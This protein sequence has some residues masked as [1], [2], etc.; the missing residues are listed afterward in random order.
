[1]KAVLFDGY[2]GQDVI[3]PRPNGHPE[4]TGITAKSI[5]NAL[6]RVEDG[7][8]KAWLRDFVLM[9]C[10]RDLKKVLV[11]G[12]VTDFQVRGVKQIA[13]RH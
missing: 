4:V 1:M 6:V 2:S 9:D 12:N 5:K 10:D 7:V 8:E 11:I 13:N 3:V